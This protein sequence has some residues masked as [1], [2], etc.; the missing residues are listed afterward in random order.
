VAGLPGAEVVLA[1]E[2]AP[3][4]L[5]DEGGDDVDV[6]GGVPHRDPAHGRVIAAGSEADPV[7]VL[8]RDVG[9]LSVGQ[10]PVR[11]RCADRQVVDGLGV[12]GDVAGEYRRLQQCGEAPDISPPV[13]SALGLEHGEFGVAG[14]EVRVGVVAGEPA[15]TGLTLEEQVAEE[16]GGRQS[17]AGTPYR[18]RSRSPKC[19]A[20]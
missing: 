9:P 4:V 1:G 19:S 7:D 17:R 18:S 13:R 3:P 10:P 16:P 5:P 20:A 8:G 2:N 6:V 11:L 15:L 12:L 14:D